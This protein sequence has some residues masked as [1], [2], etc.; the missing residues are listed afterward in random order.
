MFILLSRIKPLMILLTAL[1]LSV[2]SSAYSMKFE[3]KL[4][5]KFEKE[6]KSIV[7]KAKVYAAKGGIFRDNEYS[8]NIEIGIPAGALS[9]DAVLLVKKVK[10]KDIK[11]KWKKTASPAYTITLLS[12]KKFKGWKPVVISTPVEIAIAANP[13]PVHP[14][15]GEIARFT[16][17]TWKKG[18]WQRM[19]ANFY[20]PSKGM[21][22][23]LTK[24]PSIKLKVQ[25][26]T[27]KTVSGPEVARGEHLYFNETWGAEVM[28]TDRFRL[29]ELLNVVPPADAVALGVQVDIRKVPQLIADVLLG[30]DFAAKQAALQNPAI[31]QA[32][33]KADAVVGVRGQFNDPNDPNLITRV[34]L[35]CALCHVAVTKTPF[36]LAAGADPVLLPIGVPVLGP[37]N[38]DMNG[39]MILSFTP[40]VQEVTPEL[41]PQYQGWGPGRF[42]PRFFEGNPVNDNVFNPSSIPPHWN[43]TDLGDQGYTIPWIGVLKMRSNNHSLASGPECGI[44]LVLGAN[45]AW[46]TDKASILDIEI[47]NPLP[48]EFQD[49]ITV[50]EIVEPGNDIKTSDLLDIEA[51]LKSIVSPAPHDF[52]EAQAEAGWKLFYGKANCV[53][54]HSSPEGTGEAGFF[55]NIVETP[56]QGLL[57]IGI[58]TPGLRGLQHTAPYFHDGSAPTLLDVMKRYTSPDI[59][60]VP[61][62][63]SEAEL[64]ELVEYMKSL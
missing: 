61:S 51:F 14:E 36:Q 55:T 26:R 32:L 40:Y 16:G 46:G 39:G 50:A 22:V 27:L 13:L 62:D 2:A 7:I 45:G 59:P 21:V 4:E 35:T 42:D 33:I 34:G 29:N 9:T 41:I 44:D 23:T 63:L 6:D 12:K 52:D 57:A 43:F 60:Q 58:K 28:W 54:C 37:P 3:K 38:V 15:I 49:R 17:K 19:M 47:G 10:L 5:K 11:K 48:Q 53:A 20:R 64:L 1:M 56:P 31:T 18:K 8:P 30:D 25:H 24:E